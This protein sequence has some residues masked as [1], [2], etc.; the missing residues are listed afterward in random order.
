MRVTRLMDELRQDAAY[1]LRLVFRS[2]GFAT[3]IILTLTVAIGANTAIFTV[4]NALLFKSLPAVA[5]PHELARVKAGETQMA[6]ANY[7]DLRRDNS[8][9]AHLVAQRAFIAGLATDDRPVRLTGQQ[10]SD[11]FFVALAARP[12]MG[13]TYTPADTRRD[14]AVLAD[15][16]WRARFGSDPSVV[17]RV[18]TL[19]GRPFEVIGIMPREFRGFAPPGWSAD[20]WI[21]VDSATAAR[22]Q[23]RADSAFEIAGRLKPGV[24][25][26]QAAAALQVMAKR[27]RAAHPEIPDVF[28]RVSV[29]PVDGIRAFEGMARTLLPVFAFLGVLTI[30]S[31]FVLLIGCAN[32]AGMLLGRASA[33]RKEIAMRL[34]LGAGR[35]RLV[36]QLLTES[37]VLAVIGG[38]AGGILASWLAGGFSVV[39]TSLPFGGE[40]DVQ[41]D[42]RVLTYALGLTIITAVV[43]GFAPARRAARFDVMSSL[44]DDSGGSTA[45][46][47]FRRTLVVAQVAVSAALLLWSGLFVRSL[48]RIHDVDPGFDASGVLLASVTFERES[49]QEGARILQELQQRVRN[50]GAVQS[51]GLATIVPLA[52]AGREEFEVSIADA[53][54]GTSRRRVLANRLAPGW[55]ETVRIPLVS[56]RDFTW[57]DREGSA[58][59]A[60]VNDTLARQ[61]WNGEALGKQILNGRQTIDV[62][63]V[64]QDS[65]YWTLGETVAPTLYLPLHQGPA[66]SV[67]LHARTADP[68]T[69][70]RVILDE[71]ARLAPGLPVEIELMREAVA[72]AVRPAQIGAAATGAFGILAILLSA[73]GVYGLVS[74]FVA[75]R[76]REIGVRK[77]LGAGTKDIVMMIVGST[78]RLMGLGLAIGLGLGALGAVAL[79]GFIFGV[80]PMDPA[81]VAADIA[82]V[83]LAAV[84]ASALPALAASRVDPVV[85]LRQSY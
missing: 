16:T 23:D 66:R 65:K 27:L 64:V 74:F 50:S 71:L 82:I 11:N 59:V 62:V 7:E 75:Q 81:T 57:N 40:F 44:K 77:A 5:A 31:G 32:I 43:F 30:V 38:A 20:F 35:G 13:R 67:T 45:R 79:G 34:A 9:F 85:T 22:L 39:S 17:G 28:L 63:G 29:F 3:V 84:A 72:V 4:I 25:H 15:H 33:R 52:M 61:F 26:D 37:L 41:T 53:A 19:G 18:L 42:V 10:T 8:V 58:R 6:W 55:F 1:G 54:G 73:L 14:V 49:A 48:G 69:T 80:S 2:P 60:I 56:G 24:T 51:A 83:T 78:A 46:Q 12:A 68:R 36:R 70:T 76:M 47:N 21:A